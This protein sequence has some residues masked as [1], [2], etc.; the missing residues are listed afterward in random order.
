ML[1]HSAMPLV[2]QRFS[3][4]QEQ[5]EMT[6]QLVGSVCSAV[7]NS[8]VVWQVT[9]LVRLLDALDV[10]QPT[11]A[12]RQA[13]LTAAVEGLFENNSS[14][15]SNNSS[16]LL[17]S[18][19]D[20]SML[21]LSHLLLSELPLAA[22]Y[23]R[24]AAAVAAR[25]DNSLLL[26]QLLQ[27]ESV[28]QALDSA[29]VQRLV[30]F[31]VANLERSSVVPPFNW[32]MPHAKLPSHPQ[33]QLF[34]HGPAESFTLTGFTGINGARREASRFQGTYNN[35][36]PSTY[37]MT[38]TAQGVGRNACLLIRKTRDGISCRCTPGSC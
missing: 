23:G 34:L 32:R 36:K 12:A 15:S 9:G 1:Q 26:K 4:C 33:A 38:A 14:N 29:S 13:L 28:G 21:Q 3:V 27:A 2:G 17:S 20:D 24:F 5:Q 30:A 16:N 11:K 8:T 18:Q 19:T 31:Q 35:S 6:D 22:A 25:K 7:R 37:S 10:L